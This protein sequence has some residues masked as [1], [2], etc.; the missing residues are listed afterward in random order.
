VSEPVHPLGLRLAGRS[1][2]VVGGGAVGLRRVTSLLEAGARPTV[3]APAVTPLLEHLAE[4]GAIRWHQRPYAAGDVDGAWLV[5]ACTDDP[6]V[7]ATVA[8][9]AEQ[10]RIWCVRADDGEASAAW[11]PAVGRDAGLTVAVHAAGDP[12]RAAAARD[13]CIE[14]LHTAPTPSV[15]PSTRRGTVALVGAGPGD[16][17]LLTDRARQL[18]ALA[19][20]VV[21]DRLVPVEALAGLRPDVAVVDATKLPGGRAMAQEQICAELVEH[22]RAGRFVVRLKGGDPFVFGR[23]M[24]E[25]LACTEAGVPVEVVPGVS[26]AI[27]VPALAGIPVTHR[28]A[29]QAFTVVSGHVPPGDDRSTVDWA[30]LARSGATLIVLMGMTNLP[31]I[32]ETLCAAG[33]D[34]GTPVAVIQEGGTPRQRVLRSALR[35]AAEDAGEAGMRS[36]AVVVVGHVVA[37]GD[38]PARH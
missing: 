26:S 35:T 33:A 12:R 14:A 16:P 4:Q 8:A 7:N 15:R 32:T 6:A 28:G 37:A 18:L 31:A 25:V 13:R 5:Y 36:P 17:G 1:V 30:A 24:E 21:T 38:P 20:V 29:S 2:V 22:A 10:Q 34:P 3:V 27:A 19:D 23:G 11:T 9:E